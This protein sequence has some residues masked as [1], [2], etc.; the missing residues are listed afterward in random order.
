MNNASRNARIVRAKWPDARCEQVFS[1]VWLVQ[2]GAGQ[3]VKA[4]TRERA[5]EIAAAYARA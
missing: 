3:T 5:W 4:A 1:D 2:W